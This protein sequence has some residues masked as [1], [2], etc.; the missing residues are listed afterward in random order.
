M[1]HKFLQSAQLCCDVRPAL[2]LLPAPCHATQSTTRA[3]TIITTVQTA[4]LPSRHTQLLQPAETSSFLQNTQNVE[5]NGFLLLHRGYQVLLQTPLPSCGLLLFQAH[6]AVG[7]QAQTR[8]SQNHRMAWVE[9]DHNAHP[10][11]TPCCVQGHQP[12]D[13]AAHSHIQPGLEC[14]HGWGIHSLLGQPVQCVTTL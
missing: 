1:G 2:C 6:R 14:L 7:T 5:A 12:A 9:K 3:I 4:P 11:P 13:Q 10:V 8:L